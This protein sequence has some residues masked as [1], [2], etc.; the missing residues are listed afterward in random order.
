[1]SSM[2]TEILG[3]KTAPPPYLPF[4]SGRYRMAMGLQSLKLDDWIEI[5]P[6][7]EE[8]LIER[9]RL[10]QVQR[11][12]V[13]AILPEAEEASAEL[14]E[15]LADFLPRRF[16]EL[17]RRQGPRL[18][19]LTP[20][21]SWQVAPPEAHPLLIAGHLVQEDL[22]L[23][24][25][26]PKDKEAP[27][28]L[29]AAVLCFPNRWLLAEKMGEPMLAIH[30][31]VPA[32]GEK[33]ARPVDR[34]LSLLK[35]DKPVWRVNWSLSDDPAL[36]QPRGH[37]RGEMDPSI[38]RENA[39]KRVFLRCERQTLLR[40]PRSQAIVFGIRTHLHPL[41]ALEARPEAALELAAVLRS[42]PEEMARYKS[43]LVFRE[44]AIAYLEGLA[45][46]GTP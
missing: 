27:Y 12:E 2:T 46:A 45:A 24:Q 19:S 44:A 37:G 7:R 16:P 18:E 25:K 1:M 15:V 5:G 10:L 29:T 31:P 33:L 22:C 40:L 3:T 36:F 32:Y 11:E 42:I 28:R 21:G 34:F 8:Q 17:Y 14:L 9:Q 4:E 23:M 6:D 26:D 39:G 38:T 30:D 41:S 35:A 13:L 43:L 20:K